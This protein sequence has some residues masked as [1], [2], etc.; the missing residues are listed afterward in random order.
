MTIRIGLGFRSTTCASIGPG[1]SG[2][3]EMRRAGAIE[4]AL[5]AGDDGA[6]PGGAVLTCGGGCTD[7]NGAV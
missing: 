5:L 2:A 4:L 6:G 7:P 3:R 1:A